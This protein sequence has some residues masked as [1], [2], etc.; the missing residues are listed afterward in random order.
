MALASELVP[1]L[2]GLFCLG[3]G[4]FLDST[5][6]AAENWRPHFISKNAIPGC[7]CCVPKVGAFVGPHDA[8]L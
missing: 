5:S 4:Q 8:E 3:P 2:Q 1:T 7:F 6:R